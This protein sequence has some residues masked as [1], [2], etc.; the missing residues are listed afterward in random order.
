VP[1]TD[2]VF[3]LP[4]VLDRGFG[5]AR[6]CV[7]Q[8]LSYPNLTPDEVPYPYTPV[9]DS[10]NQFGMPTNSFDVF[11]DVSQQ[12]DV[13]DNT[14]FTNPLPTRGG[15]LRIVAIAHRDMTLGA[16]SVSIVTPDPI[17]YL[18]MAAAALAPLTSPLLSLYDT[19][20]IIANGGLDQMCVVTITPPL[21]GWVN[22]A[23]EAIITI[24]FTDGL[25]IKD[26]SFP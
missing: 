13:L 17:L 5:V 8:T 15:N 3:V 23:Q 20:G 18:G 7:A 2:G 11:V 26:I 16:L 1:K 21:T 12:L 10:T 9:G 6:N 14:I 25:T 19:A 22:A 24:R 4:I